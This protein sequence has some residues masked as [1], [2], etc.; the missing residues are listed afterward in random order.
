MEGP[1]CMCPLEF[2]LLL[3]KVLP[4]ERNLQVEC[5]LVSDKHN[6]VPRQ[7][8]ILYSLLLLPFAQ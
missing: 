2:P 8:C 6:P 4:C 5:T 7:V 1:L 3:T